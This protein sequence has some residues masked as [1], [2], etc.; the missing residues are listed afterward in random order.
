[1]NRLLII[2]FEDGQEMRFH[3]NHVFNPQIWDEYTAI[4]FK[5]TAGKSYSV[6]TADIERVEI[7]EE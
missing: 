1:M 5:T 2:F 7:E 3:V 4:H 6:R